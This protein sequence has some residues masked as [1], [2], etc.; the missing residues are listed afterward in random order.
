MVQRS[1]VV[2]RHSWTIIFSGFFEPMFYL[3]SLGL[4]L[5]GLVPNVDG[6]SY[7]AFVAP[8]LL[9]ASCMNGAINDGLF[10]VFFKLHEK[11]TYDGVLAT[12]MDVADVAFGELL[13][14]LGRGSLYAVAFLLTVAALEFV[15]R[16]P[17]LLS[18]WA[19]AAFPA[20][21]VI[22]ASFAAMALCTVSL[23]RR[24]EDFDIVVGLA[25]TP[26]FLFSGT[27]FPI[28]ELPRTMQWVLEAVPLYHAVEILRALTTGRV[29]WNLLWHLG[30]LIAAGLLAFGL[31]VRRLERALVT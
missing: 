15:S 26:M 23:I 12:P 29:G 22:A 31:A 28:A 20:A 25:V 2:Y 10:N 18:R 3:L 16:T 14:A 27:F 30:W 21:V 7:A 17:M 11:R 24:V 13:W 9:A 1:L 4:G 19:I 5:G 8:G 6:L